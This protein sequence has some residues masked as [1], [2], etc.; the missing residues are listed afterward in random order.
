M[1]ADVEIGTVV[2][3]LNAMDQDSSD[4]L[5]Y[6]IVSGNNFS[7]FTINATSGEIIVDRKLDREFQETINLV[8]RASD[9]NESHDVRILPEG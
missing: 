1:F 8:V 5:V 7:D 2:R 3:D 4:S 9:G 6:S